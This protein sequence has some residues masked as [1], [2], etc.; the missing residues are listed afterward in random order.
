MSFLYLFLLFTYHIVNI[1]GGLYL[2]RFSSIIFQFTYHIVNIK[3]IISEFITLIFF[4]FTYHIVN[5]K[6]RYLDLLC[7]NVKNLHIT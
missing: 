1:K 2:I 3:V 5:I 7:K 4:I 6:V